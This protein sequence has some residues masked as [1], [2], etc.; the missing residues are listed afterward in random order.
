MYMNISLFRKDLKQY[1]DRAAKGQLVIIERG[2]LE[3]AL[4]KRDDDSLQEYVKK[5]VPPSKSAE[6][7][8][9]RYARQGIPSRGEPASVE[10][11]NSRDGYKPGICK[12]HGLPLTAYGKCLQKGC[13]NA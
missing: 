13:K 5:A 12:I 7:V 9:E 3:F 8:P 1:F 2:G 11:G 4:T 10:L 6:K